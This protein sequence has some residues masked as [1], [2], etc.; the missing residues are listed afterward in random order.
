MTEPAALIGA[1]DLVLTPAFQAAAATSIVRGYCGWH[2]A[3][4]I[5]QEFVLDSDGGPVLF[6]PTLRLTAVDSVVADGVTVDPDELSWSALGIIRRHAADS[7]HHWTCWPYG[8]RKVSLNVH[9]G[10]DTV[11]D[12]V[13]AVAVSIA[14]RLPTQ[15]GGVMSETTG[16]IT[17]TFGA[18]SAGAPDASGL[19]S[20][21][22][23]VLNRYRIVP[24]P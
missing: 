19:T 12:D 13:K 8:Y 2:I 17:R 23:A 24:T 3:P 20:I 15:Q 6:V 10:Y 22:A 9:H 4:N 1:N 21:E 5:A 14:S 11:P 18:G 7:V 16:G